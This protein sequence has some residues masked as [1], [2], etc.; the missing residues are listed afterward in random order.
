MTIR[1]PVSRGYAGQHGVHGRTVAPLQARPRRQAGDARGRR[2]RCRRGADRVPGGRSAAQRVDEHGEDE[3]RDREVAA[4]QP[5]PGHAGPRAGSR[6]PGP[7]SIQLGVPSFLRSGADVHVEGLGRPEPVGV[8]D[9]LDD[10]LAGAHRPGVARPAWRAGRT[11][12][13]SAPPPAVEQHPPGVAVDRQRPELLDSP[14]PA[15]ERVVRRV[16]G[17]RCGRPAPGT[18]TASPHSRRPRA[19]AAG[20]GRS[21]RRGR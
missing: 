20:P 5:P 12:W 9:L 16:D 14:P 6:R 3:E 21:R 15:V 2:A 7:S 4:E 18:R 1:P 8:P 13:G 10:V 11:P 19:R 17:P